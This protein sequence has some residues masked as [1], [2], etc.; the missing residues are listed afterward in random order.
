MI[1]PLTSMVLSE[2][3]DKARVKEIRKKAKISHTFKLDPFAWVTS[4]GKTAQDIPA[5]KQS[6]ITKVRQLES[7]FRKARTRPC[8]GVKALK[9]QP[10][11]QAYTPNKFSPSMWCISSDKERRIAFIN[12]IKNLRAQAT[13]VYQKWKT[14]DLSVPYPLGLFPPRFPRL[15][16]LVPETIFSCC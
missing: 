4:Y 8:M 5:I 16:N 2:R 1:K 13:A 3:E 11:N 10:M 9:S 12:L 14:G 7:D 6:I 15:A